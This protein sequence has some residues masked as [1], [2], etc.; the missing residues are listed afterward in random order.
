MPI[1]VPEGLPAAQALEKENI[2]IMGR[3]RAVHQDIRPLQIL[4]LN[5]MPTK[6]DTEMQL[7]RLLSNSP[8][9]LDVEFLRMESH[10]AKHTPAEYLLKF[11]KSFQEVKAN[12][13]DGMIITGAPV[14]RL[15]F[16]QVDYWEELC[17]VM[18]WSTSSVYSTLH[19]CWGAQA[20]LYHHFGIPKYELPEKLSGVYEHRILYPAHPVLRGFDDY[21]WAPHSRYTEVRK[22][23]I[24]RVGRL[25]VLAVSREAGVYLA[26]NRNGRQFFVTGHCEYDRTTLA[27]EYARDVKKGLPV[28]VP[29]NYFRDDDPAKS[30]VMKWRGHASLLFSNWLNYFVYQR[31]PYDLSDLNGQEE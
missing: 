15:K 9:Q 4:I 23:D 10:V 7:L 22:H 11:Y 25:E 6:A 16:E 12:R 29:A 17:R 3:D 19:I 18:D 27:K 20:G 26:A 28:G 8:L 2:F 14:E 13:Y 30:P 5:L 1:T 21:F 31:T 24:D